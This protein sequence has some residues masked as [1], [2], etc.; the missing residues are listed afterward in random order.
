MVDLII[1]KVVCPELYPRF[2]DA[3]ITPDDLYS[4]L[5]YSDSLPI[6]HPKYLDNGHT[7]RE[8]PKSILEQGFDKKGWNW[9]FDTWLFISQIENETPIL[10]NT[11][12][13]RKLQIGRSLFG[14]GL[15]PID[16]P[17]G[18]VK[19]LPRKIQREWLD[20]FRFY[21]PSSG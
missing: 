10:G 19:E 12:P 15:L 1:A 6:L 5:G 20:L 21:K 4:Y 11:I 2:L 16:F 13:G 8:K 17:E 3:T 18:E 9:A 14:P 7:T